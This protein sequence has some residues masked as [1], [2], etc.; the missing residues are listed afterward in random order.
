MRRIAAVLTLIVAIAY[1]APLF[2]GSTFV[3][4]DHLTATIPA[5][6][7][8]A[9]SL[10]HGHL[11]EW[12]SNADLG[13]PLIANPA[14]SVLYPP[15]WILAFTPIP[16]GV[17][18]LMILHVLFAGLGAASLSR[19]L[20]ADNVGA[21]LAGTAF[22]LGGF[23]SSTLIHG[24]PL[25][26]LAWLPWVAWATDRVAE[27]QTLRRVL[28][29]AAILAGE[30][31]AGD[32][33]FLI[34][35]SVL[36]FG[37]VL[38]R[39]EQKLRAVAAVV[40]AHIAAVALAAVVIIPAL[41]LARAS[42]RSAGVS[43]DA[44][45]TWSL[46]PLRIL[47]LFWPQV[48]GDPNQPTEHL[49]RVVADAAAPLK[50]SP[51]WALSVYVS[52]PIVVFAV[53][54]RRRARWLGVLAL[55]FVVIALGKYTP[56]Y[57]VY[58]FAMLPERFVRYPEKYIAGTLLLVC[59]MAG[60]GWTSARDLNR[61]GLIAV[62]ATLASFAV[63]VGVVA[64]ART[65]IA[66]ALAADLSP[67][68]DTSAG[69]SRA[70]KGGLTSVAVCLVVF[71]AFCLARTRRWA[72]P[73]G[74][75]ILIAHFISLHYQTLP[76]F[77]RAIVERPP[78]ILRAELPAR[79]WGPT[80]HMTR[81]DDLL[82]NRARSLY[83]SASPNVASPFGFQYVLGYDQG[84][85]GTFN[86]W[87]PR[88][89]AAGEGAA[90]RYGAALSIVPHQPADEVYGPYALEHNGSARPRAFVTTA[91]H[92]SSVEPSAEELLGTSGVLLT[93]A[94][95]DGTG[96]DLV[97]CSIQS[98]R[99]EVVRIAC[100]APADGYAVLLD[101]YAAGWSAMVDGVD[102]KI[103]R[104]DII[105]RAVRVSAG[106]HV[107][108]FRYSTPGLFIGAIVSLSGWLLLLGAFIADLRRRARRSI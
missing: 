9:Q 59:V 32:P 94:G 24:V 5:K 80:Q 104:A 41:V 18:L 11:P 38:C 83:D 7:A 44:A 21:T 86:T 69:A 39:A 47:E 23:T 16:F 62:A 54:A 76:L 85:D 17:D 15:T 91:W 36:A 73:V 65:S 56:I 34:I 70:I 100:D 106:H 12:W 49:A 107:I 60:V 55:V 87:A 45:V 14:H 96:R 43:H 84:H 68:I 52:L 102:A 77:D 26:T 88:L 105:C 67:A 92:W 72:L 66:H 2:G 3:G 4:R 22:M 6:T 98:P 63:L 78:A 25:I 95:P 75:G 61:R 53:I 108:E 48:F 40:A 74:A 33:S 30:I 13:V 103:E 57:G 101:A 82:V 37:I 90:E 99:P 28:A 50:L 27:Q 19:R 97:P 51:A 35:G 89:E 93:G 10:S 46:H 64:I 31:M 29:L 8:I 79:L 58:R 71:G 1:A 81:P 20:G 42:A